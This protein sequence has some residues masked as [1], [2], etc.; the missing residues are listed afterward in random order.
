MYSRVR[1]LCAIEVL[2]LSL[3]AF[4]TAHADLMSTVDRSMATFNPAGKYVRKPIER[5]VPRLNFRGAFRQWGDVLIDTDDQVG[6]RGQDFRFAQLQNLL[7]LEMSY[8]LGPGLELNAVTH[9]L[10][11]G[12]YDWQSSAA[13]YADR[14]DRTVELYDDAERLMRELYVSYRRPGF[15]LLLGK[16]QVIWG[17]MDGQF[18]DIINGMDRR[19]AVQL[20]TEDFELRRLPTWMANSTF[21]FGRNS[22]QLLYIFD[23]EEDRQARPGTPW[24][25]PAIPPPNALGQIILPRV[26]PQSSDFD[27]H[28]FGM[29]FDRSAGALTYGFI[30]AW[31]WDKNPVGHVVGTTND[32]TSTLVNLQPR[33]ERLHHF[34]VTADY[35]TTL[36]DVPLVGALPSVF[37]MEAL[38][39]KGVRFQDYTKVE[40][41]RLGADTNGTAQHDTLRMALAAEF[42]LPHN[43]TLIFQ[44]SLYY[45][46]GWNPNLGYAFGG[47]IGD[48]WTLIP[49]VYV[50]RPFAFSRDRLSMNFTAFP[51]V[52]GPDKEWQGIKTKLRVKYKFSQFISTQLVYNGYDAGRP[53]EFYGQYDEWDNIGWELNYEF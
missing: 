32:G 8:Q 24:H 42:G 21:H 15:D 50:A 44:P 16:Q 48:E 14:D 33:H 45:T 6:F 43:T 37:R 4:S 38:W 18:I 31:L 1:L 5:A 51:V 29:R 40:A 36:M 19:E 39:T 23:F 34:G 41:A 22:L 53:N 46:F 20:E 27:D 17:K 30:Y 11:D 26:G 52:S 35:A 9:A 47:G 13:L 10:Y 7:E 49:V 28:E 2:C 25:S 3:A 12:V